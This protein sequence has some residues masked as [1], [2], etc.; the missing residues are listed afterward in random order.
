MMEKKKNICLGCKR[1]LPDGY[2]Y[3]YCEA[4]R[5]KQADNAKKALKIVGGIGLTILTVFTAGKFNSKNS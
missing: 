3:R 5:T 4:C 1:P 2:K